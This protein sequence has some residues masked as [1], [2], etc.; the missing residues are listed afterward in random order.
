MNRSDI[1]E[2]KEQWRRAR[3]VVQDLQVKECEEV[4]QW[5]KVRDVVQVQKSW[6][7][8]KPRRMRALYGCVG[9][10]TELSFGRGAVNT[11]VQPAT[12]LAG[13]WLEGT[14]DGKV[15]LFVEEE[16]ELLCDGTYPSSDE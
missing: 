6:Q 16:V 10:E 11:G 15:G 13:T 7:D 5:L 14:L 8:L 2:V 4:E 12:W 9:K 3:E 1:Q